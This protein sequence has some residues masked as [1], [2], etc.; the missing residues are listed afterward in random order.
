MIE[1][2]LPILME[3]LR[4]HGYRLTPQRLAILKILA[5]A[6][7]HPTVEQIYA[8]VHADFPTTSLA[9]VYKTVTL[10]KEEGELLELS[11]GGRSNRYDGRNPLPHPHLICVHCGSILDPDL[12]H[13]DE[14]PQEIGQKY[15]YQVISHRVDF[16]GICP[17]CRAPG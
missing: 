2:R 1:T 17:Q 12:T 15:G 6:T 11:L 9:T 8:Q 4:S 13:F 3:K 10:L 7:T 5:D 16:F 14:L